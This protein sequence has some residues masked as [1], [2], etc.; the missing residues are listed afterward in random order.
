MTIL[1]TGSALPGRLVSTAELVAR[2]LPNRDPA[3]IEARTG[4]RTRWFN[5]GAETVASL[6]IRCLNAA[7][8]D[9]KLPATALRRV[10]LC[11]STGF[12]YTI[13]ATVHK[14]I[15]GVGVRNTCD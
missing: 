15:S 9:A 4:I 13:P 11:S 8:E 7:L 12:D 10:I 1:G 14:V 2:A 5:E 3:D 6:A